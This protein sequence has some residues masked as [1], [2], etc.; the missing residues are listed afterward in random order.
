MTL[1]TWV[2][3]LL[4]R[5]RAHRE[6]DDEV[7]FHLEMETDANVARGMT[8]AAAR[9]AALA[10]FGGIVQAKES[11]RDVRTLTIESLW[12]DLRH[13]VRALLAHPGF[14]VTATAMLALG[15]GIT[16]AMF[17]IVDSLIL[18]PVPFRDASQLAHLW[19]GNDHGGRTLVDPAVIR[20]WRNSAA[21]QG[22]ES[23]VPEAALL[24]TGETIVTR[25]MAVITPGVFDLLG[26]VGPVKGRLFDPAEGATGESDR[27]LV[28]ETIWKTL[29][30]SDP[31]LVGKSIT[32]NG[33]RLRVVGILPAAFRFPSAD[34]VLWKPTDLSRPQELA[35]AYVRFTAKM[36]REEALRV[37]TDAARAADPANA[38]LRPWVYPLSRTDEYT[39]R[40]V[41]LLAG[42]VALVFLVLCANVCGL[43]LARLTARRREFSMR[44]ALGASRARLIRQA[45]VESSVLGGIGVAVGAATAWML[46]S[47]ARTVF[48]EQ[49]LLQTLNPLD[50]DARALAATS[51]GG[52]VATLASGLLPAWLGTRVD[53]GDSLRVVDRGNT[54]ARLARL[55]TRGLLVVEVAFACTLL[56]GATL[57]TRSFVKLARAER[58]LVTSGVTTMFLSLGTSTQ[59]DPAARLALTRTLEEELRQLPGARQVAWSYGVPPGGGMTSFGDWIPDAL[60]GR[61]VNLVLDRYVV[62]PEFFTLYEIPILKGRM[63]TSADS[64]NDVIVSQ[65]LAAILWGD[66]DPIGHT[67]RFIKESFHV[68][69]VARDI[70]LPAIDT[71]LDRPQFYHPYKTA[72]TTPMVSIRCDRGCPDVAVIRHRLALAHPTVRVQTAKLVSNDYAKELAQPRVSAAVAG[73][74]AVIAMIATAGGLFSVLS[75]AVSRRRREFGVRTALGASRSQIRRVVLRE[76]IVVTV[77]GLMVG[78]V[79]AAWLARALAS[80]EYGVTPDDPATWS[81]VLAVLGLTTLAACWIP[82]STAARC[83]PLVLLREE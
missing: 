56:V 41:P 42:G 25:G 78:A 38:P 45:L 12:L 5:T 47:L 46:V 81:I 75:Y 8:R 74:F 22:V 11:V 68:I 71:R 29:Y 10:A 21:F 9:Q 55:L 2:R 44:A 49:M 80:V 79:L 3:A 13:A 7:A 67:F 27:L 31:E 17:T 1:P 43:L 51:A 54:E 76:G 28:S 37:A 39:R 61:A 15:I 16:T 62:S 58:G 66:A 70:H 35:R 14:T 33:E 19:M 32:V 34:T 57:L 50:L 64:F 60:P 4:Q 52:V 6:L 36:P 48:P 40:A 24:E 63:F 26:G 23:A 30:G 82:A 73:S 20:A 69:G 53:T 59:N 65:R 18:R 83:D 77:S 72:S